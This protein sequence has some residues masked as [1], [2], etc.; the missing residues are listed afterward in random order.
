MLPLS[1][2]GPYVCVKS[3]SLN[4]SFSIPVSGKPPSTDVPTG[5]YPFIVEQDNGAK[6]LIVQAYAY[7]KYMGHLQLTFN[8]EGVVTSY[9]GNP[10]LL[11]N[12]VEQGNLNSELVRYK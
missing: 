6:A 7:G 8:D 9:T 11:D 12:S 3:T 4:Q 5:D 1:H 10:I 2:R